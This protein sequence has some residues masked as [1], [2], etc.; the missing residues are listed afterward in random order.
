ME[1]NKLFEEFHKKKY[2]DNWEFEFNKRKNEVSNTLEKMI[3]RH[4]DHGLVKYNEMNKKVKLSFRSLE[5]R[6]ICVINDVNKT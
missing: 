1:Y 3:E 5:I 6:E 2:G 4:G